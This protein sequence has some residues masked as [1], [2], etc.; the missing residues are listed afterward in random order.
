[1]PTETVPDILASHAL[2]FG[3]K[4]ALIEDRPGRQVRWT[5]AQLDE[6][7]NRLAHVLAELGATPGEKVV[8]C[9]PNSPEVV[10]AMHAARKLGV[11]SVPLNYRLSPDEAAYVIDNCDAIVVYVDS[12]YAPLISEIRHRIPKVKAVVVFGGPGPE[13]TLDG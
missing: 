5:F 10:T 1:M 3:D 7:S 9:G 2:T 12:E 4:P 8:W 6:A 13:G 11:T